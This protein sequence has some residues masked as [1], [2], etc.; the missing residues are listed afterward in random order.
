[1]S[2]NATTISSAELT[3]TGLNRNQLQDTSPAVSFPLAVHNDIDSA[4]TSVGSICSAIETSSPDA[5]THEENLK[6]VP[7]HVTLLVHDHKCQQGM[8]PANNTVPSQSSFVCTELL[9]SIYFSIRKNHMNHV[10]SCQ[11]G[12]SC[13]VPGGSYSKKI[14]SHR[15][16]C[17]LSDCCFCLG[18]NNSDDD[19]CKGI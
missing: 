6:F 2:I 10:T 4:P 14:I 18:L 3:K 1:M 17:C 16:S 7:D 11:D 12:Q 19:Y 8:N 9:I 5:T 13:Q 15:R